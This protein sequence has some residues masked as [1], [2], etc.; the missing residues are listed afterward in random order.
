VG[1]AEQSLEVE[2]PVLARYEPA[3]QF[4]GLMLPSGQ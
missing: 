1:Q 3:E 4:T 2:A